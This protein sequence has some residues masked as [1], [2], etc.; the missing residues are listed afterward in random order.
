MTDIIKIKVDDTLKL[1]LPENPSTGHTWSVFK[2][3]LANENQILDVVDSV[4]QA[5]NTTLLGAPG[6]LYITLKPKMGLKGDLSKPKD[7]T[8]ELIEARPWE[9]T[10]VLNA[11]NGSIDWQK[12]V[13]NN[14]FVRVEFITVEVD[15]HC[16]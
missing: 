7:E 3:K 14:I 4:Y 6:I 13:L 12:A 1:A 11:D 5:P 9:L 2:S 16:E 10:Q 15:P 8:I